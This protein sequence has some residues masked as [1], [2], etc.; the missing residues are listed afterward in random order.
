MDNL[1]HKQEM[2]VTIGIFVNPGIVP[3]LGDN[4]QPR[5][6]RSFEYDSMGDRYA[7]F[8]L[9]E[10]LPAAGTSYNLS[11][12]PNDRAIAGAS[13]GAICALTVAWERPDAF[14]RVLSTI[15]TYVGLRGGNEYATLIRKT[16]PKPLRIFLQDGSQDLDIYGGNWW[17]AN[18]DVLSALQ[19]AGYDVEHAW[20]TGGHDGQH[21]ATILPGALR[22]LWRDYPAPLKPGRAATRRM[23][24]LIDGEDWQLVSEGHNFTEGPAV[25]A[26]GD[27]FFT[28]I[29]NNRIHKVDGSGAVSVFVENSPKVNGLMFGPDGYLYACQNG[30]QQIVRYDASGKEDVL[31][32]DAPCNDLVVLV[33]GYYYTDP[34]HKKVWHVLH[35]PTCRSA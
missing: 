27:V 19:F 8:L 10:I 22:W 3:P 11:S 9:E 33:N 29:P 31:V 35:S 13:S 34:E 28:D 15:G 30:N 6:N 20:G 25:N 5:F 24:I 14:R 26:Q 32:R 2:P 21:A 4:T 12:D 1:I 16:E 18:Q 17:I 23:D 7:R